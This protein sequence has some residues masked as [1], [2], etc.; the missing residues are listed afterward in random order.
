MQIIYILYEFKTPIKY[1]LIEDMIKKN[2]NGMCVI[3]HT[4]IQKSS[5]HLLHYTLFIL[6]FSMEQIL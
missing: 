1:S 5:L 3:L 4:E 6:E 2:E